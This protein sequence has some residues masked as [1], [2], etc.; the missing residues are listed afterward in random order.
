MA[1]VIQAENI[2]AG[3]GTRPVLKGLSLSIGADGITGIRGPNGAGKSSFLKLCLGMLRVRQGSL[4][5]LGAVPGVPAFRKTL[6]RI[7]YVPQN[8]SGGALPVTVREAVLMGRCGMA[9]LL[10]PLG[11]KDRAFAAAAIEELGLS[12]LAE[13]RVRELSGGQ[14]QRTAIARALA[15]EAELLLLDEP[16]ASLDREG[17]RDLLRILLDLREKRRISAVIVSHN[18]ETLSGCDAVYRLENGA[19]FE[20]APGA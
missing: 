16:T 4:R 13:R 7:G 10:R 18:E 19:A 11:R 9:G 8:T 3:Y 1:P 20:E 14:C 12:E 5:V 2:F 17:R 15:M 6:F